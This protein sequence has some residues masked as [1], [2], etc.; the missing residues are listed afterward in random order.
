MRKIPSTDWKQ[1]DWLVGY[2]YSSFRNC[3][4]TVTQ[5]IS[6]LITESEISILMHLKTFAFLCFSKAA[7]K[8]Q[9]INFLCLT[10]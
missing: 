9:M 2:I 4:S 5:K 6:S 8:L 1:T 7:V 10:T 3:M